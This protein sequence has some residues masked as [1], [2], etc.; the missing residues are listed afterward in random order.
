MNYYINGDQSEFRKK[1]K[2]RWQYT[3]FLKAQ[4]NPVK[5]GSQTALKKLKHVRPQVMIFYSQ[6]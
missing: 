6:N 3:P 5:R 2:L 4:R 1:G